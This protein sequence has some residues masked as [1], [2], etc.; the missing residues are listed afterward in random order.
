MKHLRESIKPFA[1]LLDNIKLEVFRP[2]ETM[3]KNK[4]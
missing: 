2:M 1:I 3:E 4:H